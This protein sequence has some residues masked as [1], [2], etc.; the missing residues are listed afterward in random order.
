MRTFAYDRPSCEAA[1]FAPLQRLRS[2]LWC[3]A[4]RPSNIWSAGRHSSTL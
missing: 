3:K 4:G 2:S 1:P